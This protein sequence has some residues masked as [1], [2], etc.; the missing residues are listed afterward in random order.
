VKMLSGMLHIM[1]RCLHTM[2]RRPG[3][4]DG[5]QRDGMAFGIEVLRGGH[6]LFMQLKREDFPHVFAGIRATELAWY[7]SVRKEAKQKR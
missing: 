1:E 3:D 2:E 6:D 5:D 4:Y 7:D